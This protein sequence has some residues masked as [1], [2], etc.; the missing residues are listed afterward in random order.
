MSILGLKHTDIGIVGQ[1]CMIL[2]TDSVNELSQKSRHSFKDSDHLEPA[3]LLLTL[4]TCTF[5]TAESKSAGHSRT[6]TASR[7]TMFETK[8]K[9]A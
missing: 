6:S 1:A 8:Q 2:S 4:K 7:L 9:E 5:H 3:I